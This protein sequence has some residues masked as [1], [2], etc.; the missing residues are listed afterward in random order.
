MGQVL[1]IFMKDSKVFFCKIFSHYKGGVFVDGIQNL[2]LFSGFL[3]FNFG[4]S[5]L[6][7]INKGVDRSFLLAV[8]SSTMGVSSMIGISLQIGNSSVTDFSIGSSWI[9]EFDMI[10]LPKEKSMSIKA[11]NFSK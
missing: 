10:C 11:R 4:K 3:S 6:I 1:D 5:F 7:I 8:D 9:A 2:F